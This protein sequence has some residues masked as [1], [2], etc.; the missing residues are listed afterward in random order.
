MT[1]RTTSRPSATK[2]PRSRSS[3]GSPTSRY[4]TTRGSSDVSTR[5]SATVPLDASRPT[6]A[7]SSR[8]GNMSDW[9]PESISTVD[10][11]KTPESNRPRE[12]TY[13]IVREPPAPFFAHQRVVLATARTL[14]EHVE[15][16]GLGEVAVAP[17]DVILDR[18]R[19]LVVQPDIL[20]VS[21]ERLSIVREQVWGAPDLVV[22]VFSSGGE[23]YDRSEKYGWY[24]QYG[25]RE[26][27]M[28]NGLREQ[29]IVNDF[30]GATPAARAAG[31]FDVV[32]S[33]I[34][35]TLVLRVSTLFV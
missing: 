3:S 31:M 22:E 35:P 9:R 16:D 18:E 29:V 5:T 15:R 8:D 30:T 19:A 10:Y 17:V 27:W 32:P 14:W 4:G 13:G 26:Y 7:S 12:V 2:R 1:R 20:D 21:R 11:L 24:W 34:F 33:Q 25:V 6:M 23:E 28:I